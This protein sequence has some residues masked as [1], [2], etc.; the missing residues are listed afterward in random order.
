MTEPT[1]I[2]TPVE[3]RSST[4]KAVAITLIVSCAII[5]LACIAA[6]AVVLSVFFANAPW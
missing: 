5:A 4:S 6:T 1:D 2:Q 3:R